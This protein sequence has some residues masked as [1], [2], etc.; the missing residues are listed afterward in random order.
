[1]KN[2]WQVQID[3]SGKNPDR[4]QRLQRTA[5]ERRGFSLIELMVVISVAVLLAGLLMPALA[6]LR[7]SAHRVVS[8]SNLRQIGIG[9]QMYVNDDVS[10]SL[11]YAAQL[12]DPEAYWQPGELSAAN[13]GS[14]ED[15]DDAW[16]TTQGWTGLGLLWHFRYCRAIDVFYCPN[17]RGDHPL[18]RYGDAWLFPNGQKI[19]T[20]YHYAGDWDWETG[21]PRRLDR[22]ERL[23]LAT[24]AIRSKAELN[25]E[26]GMN[27][28]RGDGSVR[29]Q[30]ERFDEI[31]SRIPESASIAIEPTP[32]YLGL[33][34]F[35]EDLQI[36]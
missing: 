24:D 31:R 5:S 10:E 35:L 20:N 8:A 28:L 18:E 25:F 26:D 13:L 32:E 11:P 21:Q 29:W 27:I 4:S 6:E 2:Q 1:V 7:V 17:H 36:N 22:G 34:S 23:V 33:W 12:W 14:A 3:M 15:S 19:Y 16:R 9:M 30:T